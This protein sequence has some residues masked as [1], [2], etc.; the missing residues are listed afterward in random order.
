MQHNDSQGKPAPSLI[1][2]LFSMETVLMLVGIASLVYGLV[3]RVE[4]S[5]FF[6]VLIIPAVFVLRMVKK[7]DWKA[8]WAALE[9]QQRRYQEREEER[10]R[11]GK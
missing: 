6:G 4:T 10:K 11:E 1:E 7:K 2:R 5:I 9:E 3:N 8:H